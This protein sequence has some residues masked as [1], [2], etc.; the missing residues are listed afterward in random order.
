M[1][2]VCTSQGTHFLSATKTTWSMLFRETVAVYCENHT[3]CLNTLCVHIEEFQYVKAG[4]I[5]IVTTKL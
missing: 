1:H 4:D 5:Y 3:K 2:S